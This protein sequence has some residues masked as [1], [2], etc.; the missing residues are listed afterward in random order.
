MKSAMSTS[1]QS[2][3]AYRAYRV[4]L[5]RLGKVGEVVVTV[6]GSLLIAAAAGGAIVGLLLF[7]FSL[8]SIG[9]RLCGSPCRRGESLPRSWPP[10]SWTKS[11]RARARDESDG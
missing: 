4:A 2:W 11:C 9:R 6:V 7:P 5:R 1:Y 10:S 8:R 3:P